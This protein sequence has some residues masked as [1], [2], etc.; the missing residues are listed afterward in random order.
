MKHFHEFYRRNIQIQ[1]RFRSG[2]PGK[3]WH[4]DLYLH[5]LVENLYQFPS[6]AEPLSQICKL[7][8]RKLITWQHLLKELYFGRR[9]KNNFQAEN[10]TQAFGSVCRIECERVVMK[11]MGLGFIMHYPLHVT[12]VLPTTTKH[13]PLIEDF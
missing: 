13:S 8:N 2:F 9:K 4:W 3:S 7:E 5:D 6:E 12:D 11:Y 10:L 1:A